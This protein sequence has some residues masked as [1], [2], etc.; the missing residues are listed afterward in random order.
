MRPGGSQTNA[1][2]ILRRIRGNASIED[3][4]SFLRQVPVRHRR[5]GVLCRL[6]PALGRGIDSR[7]ET[8]GLCVDLPERFS[9]ILVGSTA[10]LFK[11]V[12]DLLLPEAVRQT[13]LYQVLLQKNLRYLIQDVGG[14]Q[15]VYPTEE[16]PALQIRGAKVRRKLRGTGRHTDAA[17]FS[18]LDPGADCGH[19][20]GYQVFLKE[21]T[22]EMKRQGQLDPQTQVETVDQ[23]LDGLQSFAGQV[24]D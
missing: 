3:E 13:K 12:S 18:G 5:H 2:R 11:G 16:V 14:I 21:L 1:V 9:R 6:R 19:F 7:E 23:L 10:G 20:R 15:N 4:M 8:D 24:A 17:R 22:D